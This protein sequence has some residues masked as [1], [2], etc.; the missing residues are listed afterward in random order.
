M[1]GLSIDNSGIHVFAFTL[2]WYGIAVVLGVWIA[3][4]TAAR[5]AAREGRDPGLIW[6]G[7]LRVGVA[8]LLGARLWYVLFPPESVV[9]NGF[10]AGWYLTHF[11]D[12]NHGVIALWTGGLGLIG[13]VIG[14]GLGLAY[15]A[16]RRGLPILP[17]LDIAAVVLPLGQT[18]GR[19]GSAFSQDLYGPVTDLPWGILIDNADLRVGPYTDLARYPLQSTR[20]HPLYVYESLWT[21]LVFAVLLVIFLRHRSRLRVGDMALLYAA[22]YGAGRFLLEFVR[23]NVS[24]VGGVNISQAVIAGVGLMA[25]AVLLWRRRTNVLP[26]S[27]SPSRNIHKSA[28]GS[29]LQLG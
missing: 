14:G 10:T 3:A 26:P 8:G 5:L 1:S 29:R 2:H 25:I 4:E 24:L 11:F 15:F 12:V 19:L 20:F 22:L 16:R 18:V 23:V 13:G 28:E 17:W 6:P 27:G 21:A 7:L 9:A